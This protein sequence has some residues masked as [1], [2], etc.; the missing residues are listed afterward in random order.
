MKTK[1]VEKE[2]R[3][4]I[5]KVE[6]TRNKKWLKKKNRKDLYLNRKTIS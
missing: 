5:R 4:M 2:Q 6:K 3:R 1:K